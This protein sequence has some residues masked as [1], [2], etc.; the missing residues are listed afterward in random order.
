LPAEGVLFSLAH[1]EDVRMKKGA[2]T[3]VTFFWAAFCFPNV[4][5]SQTI[6]AYG[7]GTDSCGAY[8]SH[9]AAAP[10]KSV[11][12]TAPDDQQDYYSK[13][14]T[15][16]E[17]L[18]GFVSGYNASVS[19]PEKQI[20]LDTAGVDLHVRNWCAQNPTSNIFTAVHQLIDK[21]DPK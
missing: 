21:N 2:I 9:I 12:R 20:Q 4:C 16:L 19:D 14:T 3:A 5:V 6:L 7:V 8:I 1:T 13:S 18:L 10:G 15:Y 17:W 11:S